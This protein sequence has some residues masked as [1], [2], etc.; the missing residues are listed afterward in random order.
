MIENFTFPNRH[1]QALAAQLYQPVGTIKAFAL[2]AHCFTCSKDLRA[3]RE[4]GKALSQENIAMFSFDF[5]GL[6]DSEG[7]FSD[8]NFSSSV[9]DVLDAAAYLSEHYQAPQI[10]I[11]HSLGG[12]AALMAAPHIAS[13]KT[14]ISIGAPCQP[15]HVRY[16]LQDALETIQSQG[17]A[18]VQ[19]AGRNFSIKKQFLD[20]I[21]ETVI[22]EH[23]AT[24]GRQGK[25]LLVMH[26][27]TDNTVGIDNAAQIFQHA[28]HPKSF[29]SL[30][31][32]NHL[33]TKAADAHYAARVLAT[34]ASRYLEDSSSR[35]LPSPAAKAV[36]AH[37]EIGYFTDIISPRH[38]LIADEPIEL[39]GTDAGPTPFEYLRAALAACTSITLRMYANR[40]K[41]ALEAVDTYVDIETVKN[42]AGEKVTHFSI[43]IALHGDLDAEQ[44]A[45]LLDI[46]TRCPVHRTLK[47]K[48][49]F[50]STLRS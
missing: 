7:D 32:A 46:S 17:C 5:T 2:F 34:W 29:V 18:T 9:E 3:V 13:L 49:S 38:Q 21:K 1:A 16:L 43:E 37:T 11:G 28:K 19:L 42:E 10:L 20:D 39:A 12:A 27:P 50:N 40:K 24:L 41:W 25:A 47:G 26:A 15:E 48:M 8:S 35:T 6:G 22:H 45:K 30:D 14:V 36:I 31:D 4:I 44:R 33:L 23:I